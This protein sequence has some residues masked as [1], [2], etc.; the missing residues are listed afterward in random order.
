MCISISNFYLYTYQFILTIYLL[1]KRFLM[2]N[3][4]S[5]TSHVCREA[6]EIIA[7]NIEGLAAKTTKYIGAVRT[8]NT[9]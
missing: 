9:F 5:S 8:K 4:N 6:W 1:S 2:C 3:D 7:N